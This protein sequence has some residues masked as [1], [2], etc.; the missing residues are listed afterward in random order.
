MIPPLWGGQEGS[1]RCKFDISLFSFYL[2]SAFSFI[3]IHQVNF[4]SPGEL[5]WW[6]RTI[7]RLYLPTAT[8]H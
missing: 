6:R 3:C 1:E 2:L 4:E 5:G 7:V 8:D